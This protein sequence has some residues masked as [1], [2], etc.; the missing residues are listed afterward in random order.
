MTQREVVTDGQRLRDLFPTWMGR[1]FAFDVETTGLDYVND[2]LLGLALTFDDGR[3]YYLAIAH[4][5]PAEDGTYPVREH[6][7]VDDM[8][9]TISPLFLQ[10]Q[11]TMVA[12]NFKFDLHFLSRHGIEVFGRAADTVLAAQLIDE[13]RELGLKKLAHLVD[14]DLTP[15]SE[16][17][18][19]PGFKKHEILGVPFETA[20]SY[21]MLDTEAT[22]ALWHRFRV[23]LVEQGVAEVFRNV[24]MPLLMV[25]QQMEAKGIRLDLDKVREVRSEYEK[26]A[27]AAEWAV[28]EDGMKMLLARYKGVAHEEFPK[29]YLRMATEADLD[30][31]ITNE[32]GEQF[33]ELRGLR[34]PIITPT[35]R[36]KPRVP[37][38]NIGS[39]DQLGD[40]L[41]NWYGI[42]PPTDF[43]LKRKQNGDFGVDK[44]TLK[45]IELGYDGNAPEILQQILQWRKASKFIGTY[46][47][48]FIED[49]E[50][51]PEQVIR[52]SFNQ[53]ITDTGRLSSSDPNLQNIPSRG[54]EGAKARS[55]FV[56]RPGYKLI[57][58][59]YSMMELRIAAHYSKDAVMLKAFAEGM[60]LHTLMAAKN[61]NMPY[62]AMK[63][64][65]DAGDAWA[66]QQRAIGKTQNFGLLYGMGPPKFRTYLRVEIGLLLPLHEVEGLVSAFDDLYAGVTEWKSDVM[67][68]AK[69][70]GYTENLYGRKR[71]LLDIR[72]SN[73]WERMRAER[74]GVNYVVQGTCADIMAEGLIAI[75]PALAPLDAHLLLQVH[76][77]AVA[78]APEEN[79]ESAR[80]IMQELMTARI[81]PRLRCPLVVE[82][83]VG[84]NWYAAK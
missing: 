32:N 80:I 78:E 36:S 11:Q 40:L 71:R 50:R 62:E 58:A 10:R 12:H 16:L 83:H 49:G 22:L 17:V 77:E 18:A 64:K 69:R 81:N 61:N 57:V 66:K 4:T 37:H 75:Q 21:A 31:V 59:D 1:D 2:R 74:Q 46:L 34:V 65:V 60:D 14:M 56:A 68:W 5:E 15:Y 84:D 24:W 29:G 70:L 43:K 67:R 79:A 26:I 28:W 13:N 38:F 19:Y 6:L 33:V 25:L 63:E 8:V 35:P 47:D 53:H 39:N 51:D 54:P 7:N 23:E 9:H 3:S 82:A 42:E 45:V 55:M 76:D 20:A 48:R 27:T 72:S 52:T 73:R 44:S 41:Y 30:E